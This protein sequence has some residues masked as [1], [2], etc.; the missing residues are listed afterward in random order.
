M[1]WGKLKNHKKGQTRVIIKFLWKPVTL[2]GQTRWLELAKVKQ[3]SNMYADL[4]EW[5]D[6]EWADDA[7]FVDDEGKKQEISIIDET[8]YYNN[9]TTY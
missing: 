7:K 6:I 9:V 4:L 8:K 3:W 1:R 5:E 2:Q